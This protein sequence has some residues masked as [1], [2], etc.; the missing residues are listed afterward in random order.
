[1]VGPKFSIAGGYGYRNQNILKRFRRNKAHAHGP[2]GRRAGP[3]LH[4]RVRAP[5]RTYAEYSLTKIEAHCRS[6][7]PCLV[8]FARTCPSR[9]ERSFEPVAAFPLFAEEM[10]R[11]H[12]AVPRSRGIK[13]GTTKFTV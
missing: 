10:K 7:Q 6:M 3:D 12:D 9:S 13:R 1:M 11:I 8:Q 4:E 2:G 5:V